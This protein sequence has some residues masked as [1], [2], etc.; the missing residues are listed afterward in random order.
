MRKILFLMSHL[1][2]PELD[3]MMEH[4]QKRTIDAGEVLIRK[5][6]AIDSL[7]VILDGT[8]EVL[9]VSANGA[10][11]RAGCGEVLGEV[12]MLDPRPPM[13]TVVAKTD[14]V[15][16]ALSLELLNEKLQDDEAFA[17]HF[18]HSLALLLAHR[19]RKTV[20]SLVL[21]EG[22]LFSEDEEY[23]DELNPEMLDSVHLMGNRFNRVLQ[24]KLSE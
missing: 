9:G 24:Q 1:S 10:P 8:V 19:L 4:G 11:I 15:V 13:A 16:L 14:T 17:A 22:E 23:E 6:E 20:R 12:S 2:E 18:Y 5:G 3:W 7:F 21:G